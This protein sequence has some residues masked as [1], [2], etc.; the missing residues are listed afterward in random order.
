M[1]NLDLLLSLVR[2]YPNPK[3]TKVP[4]GRTS[5]SLPANPVPHVNFLS[6]LRGGRPHPAVLRY[7]CW[8]CAQKSIQAGSGDHM[9]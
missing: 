5:H 8:L 4:F 6:F 2:C 3:I 7:Y 1:Q 9:R